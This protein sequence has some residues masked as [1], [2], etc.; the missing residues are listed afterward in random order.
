VAVAVPV[1]RA[2][3]FPNMVF[4]LVAESEFATAQDALAATIAANG[5]RV[6]KTVT[7]KARCAHCAGRQHT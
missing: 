7:A 3:L 2:V 5:G 6:L 4:V 1:K